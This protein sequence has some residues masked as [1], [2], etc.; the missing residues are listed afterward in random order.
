VQDNISSPP[1]SN[2]GEFKPA[3][4]KVVREDDGWYV[5][6]NGPIGPF[7]ARKTATDVA[8]SLVYALREAGVPAEW[9]AAS[10]TEPR[11]PANARKVDRAA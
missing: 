4:I 10:G 6:H 2:G 8:V 3:V 5:L 9:F 7:E 1:G 11:P